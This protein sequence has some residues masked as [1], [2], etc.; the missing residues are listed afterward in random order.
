MQVWSLGQE[1]PLEEG[2][3]IDS[4]ILDRKIS[5]TEKPGR[6]QS[7][8]L[9]RV[10]HDWSDWAHVSSIS[11]MLRFF[12]MK[13]VEL[14][15]I[16]FL[17]LLRYMIFIFHSI[18]VV[19]HIYWF[20]C[21]ESSLHPRDK[22]HLIMVCDPFNVL[23]GS[24]WEY[25][26]ENFCIYIHQG[27]LYLYFV[28]VMSLS[29]F[30]IRVSVSLINKFGNVPSSSVFWKSLKR[31]GFNS[32]LNVLLNSPVKSSGLGLFCFG[33]FFNITDRISLFSADLLKFSFFMIQ[34]W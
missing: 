15:Q 21:V 27:Y 7:M 30:A 25:F 11:N 20:E 31:I 23:L 24:I 12:I 14:Y 32:S 26:V 6:V 16:L 4:S 2:M 29:D 10:G 8:G 19:Y 3:A 18:N 34:S 5:W 22:S 13:D 17:L 28:C 33:R 9:Q 1:D